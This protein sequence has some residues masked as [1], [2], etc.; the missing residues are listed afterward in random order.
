MKWFDRWFARKCQETRKLT[1]GE[2][3]RADTEESPWGDGMRIN[4]AKII[5]GTVISFRTW[6]ERTDIYEARHYVI[7]DDKAFDQE[8]ARL[9][10]LETMRI[11]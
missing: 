11:K 5:G 8:L 3:L 9:I 7:G 6:D 2:R 10:F 4:V 1:N